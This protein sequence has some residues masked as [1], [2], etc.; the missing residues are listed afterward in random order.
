MWGWLTLGLRGTLWS[1]GTSST[2]NHLDVLDIAAIALKPVAVVMHGY[3]FVSLFLPLVLIALSDSL[4]LPWPPPTLT[5]SDCLWLSFYPIPSCSPLPTSLALWI[6]SQILRYSL[7]RGPHVESIGDSEVKFHDFSLPGHAGPS[8]VDMRQPAM[9]LL[10]RVSDGE[11][12][13][14]TSF[15]PWCL[16][17]SHSTY[18]AQVSDCAGLAL[19]SFPTILGLAEEEW[20]PSPLL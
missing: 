9:R 10:I 5:S 15:C 8:W 11:R 7:S 1:L 17:Q 16:P 20:L 4:C 3:L 2:L 13:R 12:E 6:L 19:L 18:S 14:R